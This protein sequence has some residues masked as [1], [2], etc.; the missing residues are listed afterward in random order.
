MIKTIFSGLQNGEDSFSNFIS[1]PTTNIN[2]QESQRKEDADPTKSEEESFFNQVAPTEKEKIKLDKDSI[3]ALYGSAPTTNFNQFVPTYQ[4]S[5]Y[6]GFG[7]FSQHQQQPVI[8]VQNS[9]QQQQG[10]QWLQ[11]QWGK[12]GQIPAQNQVQYV[13][14][15][16]QFPSQFNQF[17]A[18]SQPTVPGTL[19]PQHYQTMGTFPQP[20]PFFTPQNI[21]QQFSNMSLGNS[22]S[23]TGNVW[24]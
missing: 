19:Y 16:T 2:I 17:Q 24:Q 14:N 15:V 6:Q 3:L 13:P 22:T 4:Q 5:T 11:Q 12:Q 20:N 7:G 9:V 1:A 10:A 23:N 8:P 21:Q 18:Q